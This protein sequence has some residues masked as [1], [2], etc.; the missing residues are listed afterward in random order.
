LENLLLLNTNK[1]L[2][3]SDDP[4]LYSFPLFVCPQLGLADGTKRDV[5]GHHQTYGLERGTQAVNTS[6][7]EMTALL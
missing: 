3:T 2:P 4:H 1:D 5:T 6:E 7:R